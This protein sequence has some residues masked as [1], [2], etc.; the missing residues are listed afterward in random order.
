MK[1]KHKII[2]G[3]SILVGGLIFSLSMI[4]NASI[5]E[6]VSSKVVNDL[7]AGASTLD[8]LI[9]TRFQALMTFNEIATQSPHFRAVVSTPGMDHATVLDAAKSIQQVINSDLLM[10]LNSQGILMASAS[11]PK[12]FGDDLSN[13]PGVRK[14]LEGKRSKQILSVE[15]GTYQIVI[16][17]ILVSDELVGILVSGFSIDGITLRKFEITTNSMIA[18]VDKYGLRTSSESKKIFSK[19]NY[20]SLLQQNTNK[21]LLT[22]TISGTDFLILNTTVI[23]GQPRMLFVRSLDEELFF[24]E[25]LKS[26][27]L[28][29]SLAIL[30]LALAIGLLFSNRLTRPI[31]K[32]VERANKI[33]SGDLSG[34]V[35][36]KSKDEIGELAKA[37]ETMSHELEKTI[38]DYENAA[39]QAETANRAKS[40]FLANMS[41]ELRTPMHGI[42]SYAAFGVKK[43]SSA[44]TNQLQDYFIEIQQCALRL[45]EILNDLLDLAKLE[46]GEMSCNT[47]END[48]STI[49]NIVKREMHALVT[50]KNLSLEV[51]LP[52]I[53]MTVNCDELRILQVLR[54]LVSNSHKFTESN[55]RIV[56][57]VKEGNLEHP[58]GEVECRIISVSDTGVGIPPEELDEIFKQFAQSSLTDKG[59]GG[60]GLGLAICARIIDA[61]GGWIRAE[62]N[63]DG[64]AKISFAIPCRR[65]SSLRDANPSHQENTL[66]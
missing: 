44:S 11:E 13:E 41:H 22:K 40:A 1:L 66:I 46:A 18:F 43:I 33:A 27:L 10:V 31:S 32:L 39:D 12:R 4:G 64:G 9:K 19:L 62:N 36:V 45:M 51:E 7:R 25:L 30:V 60:T 16:T 2:L 49:I 26:K 37:F 5:K 48:L 58:S 53:D 28:L 14:V 56:I 6:A 23:G 3:I 35:S 50:E 55:G 34:S 15:S 42:L 29:T 38:S 52:D 54:N 20:K 21:K 65:V 47:A 61:H 59:T 8:Y 17:P 63:K 57:S 24:Y